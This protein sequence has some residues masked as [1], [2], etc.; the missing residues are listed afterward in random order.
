[1]M[2]GV[3]KNN[4]KTVIDHHK[5][6]NGWDAQIEAEQQKQSKK[7]A[8]IEK[9]RATLTKRKVTTNDDN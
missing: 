4:V 8:L 7:R 6:S 9:M 1:M 3:V 5:R 2:R